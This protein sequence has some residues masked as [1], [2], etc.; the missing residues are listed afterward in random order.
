MPTTLDGATEERVPPESYVS[1]LCGAITTW[2]DD[3][4]TLNDE[5]QE[6]LDP[7]SLDDVKDTTLA[8]LDDVIAA[9]DRMLSDVQAAGVPTTDGGEAARRVS[10]ALGD[11]RD[12]LAGARDR[13]EG[14]RTTTRRRSGRSSRPSARI[15]GVLEDTTGTLE[16]F[17]VPS[18]RRP[19][20]TSRRATSSRREPPARRVRSR[21]Y[22][23]RDNSI[24]G[25]TGFEQGGERLGEAGRDLRSLVKRRNQYKRQRRVR[26]RCLVTR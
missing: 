5:L 9:T 17:E 2:M 11:V 16:S 13:V 19:P 6:Q 3:V 25:C 7:T 22:T 14:L 21:P 26:A 18:W 10:T 12:A 4:Q 23:R 1:D 20:T 15:A 8:F 24:R